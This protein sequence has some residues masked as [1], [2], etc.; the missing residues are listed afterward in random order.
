MSGFLLDPVN[1]NYFLSR[2]QEVQSSFV[3]SP[4]FIFQIQFDYS[5]C[6]ERNVSQPTVQVC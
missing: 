1:I 3:F 4:V 2:T 6:E 5:H